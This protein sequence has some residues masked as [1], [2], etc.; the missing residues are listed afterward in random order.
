MTPEVAKESEMAIDWKELAKQVGD[1]NPDG[2]ERGSGTQSGQR[3]LQ[4]L[5]GEEN[6]RN[7]VDHF[8]SLEPGA[9]TVEMV[10]KIIG[11]EIA[12][13]RCFEIY[14]T[15][16]DTYRACSAVFL[17]GSMA[18]YRALSWVREFL[19][20]SSEAVRLNGL[21]VLQNILY[22]PLGDA[23]IT[24]ARELIDKADSDS[25]PSVRERAAQIRQ[26]SILRS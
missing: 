4:I 20:D 3:A 11:S 22:G 8:I 18:D 19:E 16:P 21:R 14:K 6:L 25:D 24:T 1:L 15:E 23:D 7:A 2:S 26:H 12:M 9:F 10:L 13:N 5:I 17:L